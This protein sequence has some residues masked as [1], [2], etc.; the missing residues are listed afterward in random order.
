M[1]ARHRAD[2]IWPTDT[3]TFKGADL[4][5]IGRR[6][7]PLVKLEDHVA[8]AR[9][10]LGNRDDELAEHHIVVANHSSDVRVQVDVGL[11]V[12]RALVLDQLPHAPE[13]LQFNRDGVRLVFHVHAPKVAASATGG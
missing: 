13:L 1:S 2:Y 8:H 9:P 5:S 10:D 4:S 7:R 12:P 6:L 3:R 11:R